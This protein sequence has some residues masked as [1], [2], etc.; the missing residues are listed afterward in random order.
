MWA[1]AQA[2]CVGR[3]IDPNLVASRQEIGQLYRHLIT[4]EEVTDLRILEGWRREAI[5]EPLLA[6]V[7]GDTG[8]KMAWRGGLVRTSP[9]EKG[10]AR[11]GCGAQILG[12][13]L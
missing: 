1:L 2:V 6:M 7:R 3:G 10:A 5:G 13:K 12:I 11:P 4:G 8:L 9:E